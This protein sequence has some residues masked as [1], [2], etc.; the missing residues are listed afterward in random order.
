MYKLN[1]NTFVGTDADR[2]GNNFDVGSYFVDME[3]GYQYV[4]LFTGDWLRLNPVPGTL[5]VNDLNVANDATI[6][7]NITVTGDVSSANVLT[8][9]VDASVM[10][11]TVDLES[12]YQTNIDGRTTI[13]GTTD[14]Y[15]TFTLNG[16]PVATTDM[17][18]SGSGSQI[19]TQTAPATSTAWD[20]SATLATG[21]YDVDLSTFTGMPGVTLT[22]PS[23]WIIFLQAESRAS[24]CILSIT[25]STYSN[26]YAPLQAVGLNNM[27]SAMLIVP[28]D[29]GHIYLTLSVDAAA[30]KLLVNG[31]II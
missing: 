1:I 22:T 29:A 26:V 17:I 15:G 16:N 19:Y 2:T 5:N 13:S 14:A 31:Y 27:Q 20:G 11:Y 12:P 18:T 4:M 3:T 7:H 24:T 25:D 8:E 30:V 10:V 9:V 21:N 28:N 23:N 6:G